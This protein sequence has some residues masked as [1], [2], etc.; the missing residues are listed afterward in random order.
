MAQTTLDPPTGPYHELVFLC[1]SVEPLWKMFHVL[2]VT[3]AL[4]VLLTHT[5]PDP[6]QDLS[7][8]VVFLSQSVEPIFMEDV[9]CTLQSISMKPSLKLRC[10][11]RNGLIISRKFFHQIV[12]ALNTP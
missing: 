2:L 6:P 3:F 5:S 9:T 8:E 10:A 4:P 12:Q 1:Q 7:L 11:H